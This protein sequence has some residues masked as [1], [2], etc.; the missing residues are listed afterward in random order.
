MRLL[1]RKKTD[2]HYEANIFSFLGSGMNSCDSG[3][4]KGKIVFHSWSA[5]KSLKSLPLVGMAELCHAPL[6]LWPCENAQTRPKDLVARVPP[7]FS[8]IRIGLQVNRM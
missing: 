4:H 3:D 5:Q 7:Q 8:E 2:L 6:L 1:S